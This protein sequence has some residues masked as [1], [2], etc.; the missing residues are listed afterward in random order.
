MRM[1]AARPIRT[2]PTAI[3]PAKP[4]SA[5]PAASENVITYTYDA[6]NELTG[7]ADNYAT[8]TFTYDSGGNLLTAATSRP[9]GGPAERDPDLDLQRRALAARR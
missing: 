3:R 1:A 9:R 2:T 7:V 5:P 4:G 8:L 6:D